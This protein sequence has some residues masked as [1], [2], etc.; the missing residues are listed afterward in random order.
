MYFIFLSADFLAPKS[1]HRRD[2]QPVF[3]PVINDTF[4][5]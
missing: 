5:E 1:A 2:R 3:E 4:Q